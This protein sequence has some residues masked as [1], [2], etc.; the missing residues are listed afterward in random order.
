MYSNL[1]R[2]CRKKASIV[3]RW[4]NPVRPFSPVLC[5]NLSLTFLV[6]VVAN[7]RSRTP[8]ARCACARRL[9]GRPRRTGRRHAAAS[10]SLAFLVTRS[11]QGLRRASHGSQSSPTRPGT[12]S[13]VRSRTMSCRSSPTNTKSFVCRCSTIQIWSSRMDI[14]CDACEAR[15]ILNCA[16][17]PGPWEMPSFS[18]T[19]SDLA[20]AGNVNDTKSSSPSV[21]SVADNFS[22]PFGRETLF[23]TMRR[24][25][26]CNLYARSERR[27]ERRY[28]RPDE[29]NEAA[30][31]SKFH[32]TQTE[33]MEF[34]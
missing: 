12:L 27:I 13:F 20:F 32:R 30:M 6:P 15:D 22:R 26:P 33:A 11:R 23:P 31:S 19:R 28:I 4:P 17:P 8:P 7:A 21:E 10:G 24:Q 14:I 34:H 29:A 5:P 25:S 9:F 3:R 16:C 18:I 2:A 1:L